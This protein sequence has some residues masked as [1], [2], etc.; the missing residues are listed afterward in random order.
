MTTSLA[1]YVHWYNSGIDITEEKKHFL[2]EFQ[3]QSVGEKSIT[4]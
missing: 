2:I 1:K 3:S 4:A